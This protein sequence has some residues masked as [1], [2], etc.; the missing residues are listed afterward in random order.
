MEEAWGRIDRDKIQSLRKAA[1]LLRIVADHPRGVTGS[2]L[3]RLTGQPR[4]SVGRLTATLTGLG[5]LHRLEGA[6]GY[7]LGPE[8]ARLARAA[9]ADSLLIDAARAPLEAVLDRCNETVNLNVPR[10]SRVDV[11]LQLD[12]PMLL[13]ATN[14]VGREVPLHASSA[15]KVFLAFSANSDAPSGLRSPLPRYTGRTITSRNRLREELKRVRCDG[16]GTSVD[17]IEFGLTTVS[18]PVLRTE[19]GLEAMVSVSGPTARLGDRAL[20]RA[21]GELSRAAQRIRK[22]L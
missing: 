20:D 15:G 5:Y 1:G 8:L 14:W 22:R 6:S 21:V 4:A 9:D 19:G 13:A 16:Y 10:R 17:E 3:C 2:E 18:V 12:P 11:I 7:V